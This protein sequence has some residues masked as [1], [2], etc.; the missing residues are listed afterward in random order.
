MR[1]VDVAA[2][3]ISASLC[4]VVG[5]PTH[6]VNTVCGVA[7]YPAV[8]IP[9]V[10]AV[11]FGPWTGGIGGAI[12]I[13]IR[14]MLFH[15]D[16]LL[17][18][19]AGVTSNFVLFFVIGYVYRSS[20]GWKKLSF[21]LIIASIIIASGLLLPTILLP[22][23]SIIF[24]QLTTSGSLILFAVSILV[25]LIS[26]GIVAF[27]LREWRNFVVG[28]VIGQGLG[29]GIIAFVVWIY[30]QLF[31][32]STGYFKAPITYEFIPILFVW[33]FATETLFLL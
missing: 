6:L 24:T 17:S 32:S 23:Q 26:I 22:T 1:S 29:A 19:S 9:A 4:A 12:G 28:S 11:L 18:L 3:G 2:M 31:F 8:F 25:S 15:G 14:D 16:A 5:M 33:T 27:F 30:S 21:S 20:L 13:F 7:L 10:F